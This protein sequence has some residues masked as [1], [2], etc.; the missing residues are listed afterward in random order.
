MA[1][2]AMSA[3][4]ADP[5]GL[6]CQID[7]ENDCGFVKAAFRMCKKTSMRINIQEIKNRDE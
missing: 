2:H 3:S 7:S 4:F 5:T 6:F 1:C